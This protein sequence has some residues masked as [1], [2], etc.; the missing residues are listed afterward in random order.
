MREIF[1]AKRYRGM[2]AD[3]RALAAYVKLLRAGENVARE[4]T[5]PLALYD[6]TPSQFGVLEALYNAG[7]QCLSDLARR[8]LK[9][10]G[11]L[12]VVVE[13]LEKHRL[14]RRKSGGRDRRLV[15]VALTAKGRNL[16][17]TLA[18]G[19]AA[20]IVSVMTRLS[21]GEQETLGKL[22]AKLGTANGPAKSR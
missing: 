7:P 9:T 6:L 5:R 1:L 3:A 2:A 18:P 19:H 4:A 22:C 14:V 10:S 16:V 21:A 20:A 17:R 8:I 13:N 15:T 12:T 11:N